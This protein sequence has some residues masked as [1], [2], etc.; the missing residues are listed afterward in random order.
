MKI[1]IRFDWAF[2]TSAFTIL[3]FWCGYWYNYG[4]AY[5]YNYQLSAFD[6]PI[7]LMLMNGLLKGIDVFVYVII[8]M[9]IFSLLSKISLRQWSYTLSILLA[10]VL[11]AIRPLFV[12]LKFLAVNIYEFFKEEMDFHKV[13][14]LTNPPKQGINFI[15]GFLKWIYAG[16]YDFL[17]KNQMTLQHIDIDTSLKFEKDSNRF[18]ISAL[19]HYLSMILFLIFF[20]AVFNTAEK[21]ANSGEAQAKVDFEVSIGKLKQKRMKTEG[22]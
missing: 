15:V 5:Y 14:K 18:E 11:V 22:V 19:L 13:K 1:N 8:L 6:F 7:S 21:L 4:Y 3:L 17:Q 20:L 16:S 12:L 10:L 2:I 9:I